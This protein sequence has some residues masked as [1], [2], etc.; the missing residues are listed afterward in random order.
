MWSKNEVISALY[1]VQYIIPT[2]S[3]LYVWNMYKRK[4]PEEKTRLAKRNVSSK[5]A[6]VRRKVT[7]VTHGATVR[8]LAVIRNDAS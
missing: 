8:C 3:I 6:I 5:T 4:L 2:M 1:S 7:E